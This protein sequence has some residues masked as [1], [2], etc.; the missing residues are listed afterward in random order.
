MVKLADSSLSFCD[1]FVSMIKSNGSDP[2]K[3]HVLD[4]EDRLINPWT[5]EPDTEAPEELDTD[6]PCAFSGPL[7]YLSMSREEAIKEYKALMTTHVEKAFVESTAVL[8]LLNSDLALD[9][10]VP[11]VW[12]G[13]LGIP[14]IE[15]D[16]KETLPSSM[17]P[18]ARPVNPRLYENAHKEFIRLCSYFYTPADS[19]IASPLVIAPKPTKPFIRFC[20]DYIEINKH[21]NVPHHPI[22]KVVHA[23]EKAAG[24][25]VFLDIDMTNSFHQFKLGFRTSNILSVQTPWGLVRPLYVPEGIG[26][27]TGILQKSIMQIFDD[28]QDFMI[29]IFDNLLILLNLTLRLEL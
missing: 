1:A 6:L 4:G 2:S 15:L 11:A 23:L 24:Y 21:I 12:N 14:D 28:Y 20:G 5:I 22:P 8:D 26:P 3:L 18:R 25:K 13:I 7:H 27:A 29:T 17:R 19:A 9:V 16:F 10:F